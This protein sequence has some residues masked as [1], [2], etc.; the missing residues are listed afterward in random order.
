MNKKSIFL[1]AV[2]HLLL[3][4]Q[5]S[6]QKFTEQMKTEMREKT[7]AAVKYAWRGYKQYAWGFDDLKPLTKTGHNW[8][9]QSM[10]MTPVDAFDLFVQLGLNDEAKEAKG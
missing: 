6:A 3:V 2:I 4:S 1:T 5:T 9:K 7:K 8:Y 10:L